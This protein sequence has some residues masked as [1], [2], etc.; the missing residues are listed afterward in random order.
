MNE[1][2]DV[3][4]VGSQYKKEALLRSVVVPDP[5]PKDQYMFLGLPD[6]HPDP[7]LL[8]HKYGSSS[9][10]FYHQAKIIRYTLTSS[11]L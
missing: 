9:G 3:T 2:S 8:S 4:Q 5:D 6:P 1:N 7:I 10:S 11:V